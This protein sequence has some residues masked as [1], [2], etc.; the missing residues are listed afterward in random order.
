MLRPATGESVIPNMSLLPVA[1][2]FFCWVGRVVSAGVAVAYDAAAGSPGGL[3][4][5]ACF[6]LS[7][8]SRILILCSMAWS[9]FDSGSSE[10]SAAGTGLGDWSP[11]AKAAPLFTP[12]INAAVN[13]EA[14]EM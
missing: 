14:V 3:A 7:C 2:A 8:P 12:D 5:D 11:A 10:L 4:R 9:F 1:A 13:I 6:C